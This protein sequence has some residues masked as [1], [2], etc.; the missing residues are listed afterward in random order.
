MKDGEQLGDKRKRR[1]GD[2]EGQ[3]EKDRDEKLKKGCVVLPYLKGVTER[4]QRACQKH[5]IQLFAKPGTHQKSGYIP[6]E[7]SRPE[8]KMWGSI[9]M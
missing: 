4:L 1:E 3:D 6:K 9:P 8:Q 5:N 7:S 2:E